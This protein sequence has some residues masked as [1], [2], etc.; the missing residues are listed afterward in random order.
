MFSLKPL[1]FLCLIIFGGSLIKVFL[2]EFW[3]FVNSTSNKVPLVFLKQVGVL[4]KFVRLKVSISSEKWLSFS[5]LD[6]DTSVFKFPTTKMLS[7][8]LI[9]WLIAFDDSWK[10][11][12]LSYFGGL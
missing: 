2:K 11:T 10:K 8:L 12:F 9:D 3:L 5:P 6:P 1:Y 4:T 7:Y